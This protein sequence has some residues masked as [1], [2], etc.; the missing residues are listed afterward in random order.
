MW[1]VKA[2]RDCYQCSPAALT[3]DLLTTSPSWVQLVVILTDFFLFVLQV[4]GEAAV[5]RPH[6]C[7]RLR[8][9]TSLNWWTRVGTLE[10]PVHMSG[11]V[12]VRECVW[13]QCEHTCSQCRW[14]WVTVSPRAGLRRLPRPHDAQ[15]HG[16][17]D[18]MRGGSGPRHRLGPVRWAFKRSNALPHILLLWRGANWHLFAFLSSQL[19]RFLSGTSACLRRR[20]ADTR[21]FVRSYILSLISLFQFINHHRARMEKMLLWGRIKPNYS[22]TAPWQQTN[23]QPVGKKNTVFDSISEILML[24]AV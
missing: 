9:G 22:D 6:S 16:E 24:F 8:R 15:V 12:C 3:F 13:Y 1:P 11:R 2:P 21:W 17:A 14:I 5:H 18:Q 19:Q 23:H 20:R 7:R 4:P 10:R